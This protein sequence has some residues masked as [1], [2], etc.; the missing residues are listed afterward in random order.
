VAVSFVCNKE[1]W[2]MMMS[3]QNYFKAEITR[4]DCRDWDE[5]ERTLKKIIKAERTK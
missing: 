4:I 1:E 2:Q 5:V 3:I